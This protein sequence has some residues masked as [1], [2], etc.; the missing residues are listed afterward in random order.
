[1]HNLH[2]QLLTII[3]AFCLIEV[4]INGSDVNGYVD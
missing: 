2:G 4:L 3:F 1:M